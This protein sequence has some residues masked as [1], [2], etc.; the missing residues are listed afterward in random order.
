MKSRKSKTRKSVDHGATARV[1]MAPL[2]TQ[3][4]HKQIVKCNCK[5][6]EHLKEV[7]ISLIKIK[8]LNFIIDL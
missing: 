2:T 5:C 1:T 4:P 6:K 8:R 7:T 3:H